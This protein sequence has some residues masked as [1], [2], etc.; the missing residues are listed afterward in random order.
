M[1]L[2]TVLDRVEA[3]RKTLRVCNYNCGLAPIETVLEYIGVHNVTVEYAA[4]PAYDENTLVLLDG[5]TVIATESVETV[6]E[7]VTNWEAIDHNAVL[8]RPSVLSRLDD[9]MFR[10]EGKERMIVASRA[11][12]QRADRVGRGRLHVGFQELS[13]AKDQWSFYQALDP[14]V[15]VYIY[16][17]ADWVPPI[18]TH[19]NVHT[20]DTDEVRSFWWVIFDGAGADVEKAALLAE[21][22]SPQSYYGFWTY[23]PGIVDELSEYVKETYPPTIAAGK[24]AK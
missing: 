16:G 24:T 4:D 1:T 15:D 6:Y 20:G 7:Y 22:R 13:R 3:F 2:A 17:A 21:Q 10:S 18:S 8:E 9:T 19:I 23:D 11:I 5:E 14:V 12:E